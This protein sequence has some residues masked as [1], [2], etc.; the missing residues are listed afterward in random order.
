[1]FKVELAPSVVKE[2]ARL[3]Q[4]VPS[5]YE[6]IINAIRSLADE[7]YQGKKLKAE[8]TGQYSLR[9]G[10]YRI[11]YQVLKDRLLVWVI[12]LGHRREVYR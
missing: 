4:S 2:L 1:V 8:L 9:V 3:K 6:R 11:I 12:D 5:L 7:P 10:T